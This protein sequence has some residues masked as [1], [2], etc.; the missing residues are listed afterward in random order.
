MNNNITITIQ[1]QPTYAKLSV[2]LDVGFP[3]TDLREWSPWR[4]ARSGEA[5]REGASHWAHCP[6]YRQTA[7][8]CRTCNTETSLL[9]CNIRQFS[10]SLHLGGKQTG[11]GPVTWSNLAE[12][13]L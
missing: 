10:D 1:N 2:I 11:T 8:D 5:W 6:R 13:V 9:S 3:S 4:E 7:R 12:H